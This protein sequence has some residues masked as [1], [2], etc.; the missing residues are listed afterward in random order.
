MLDFLVLTEENLFRISVYLVYVWFCYSIDA[1]P[2]SPYFG[3]LVNHS[4]VTPNCH[5]KVVEVKGQPHLVLLASRKIEI[6]EEL[7]YDYGDRSKEALAAHPW[8]AL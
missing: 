6:G 8:L 1:T 3:R 7:L 2:E 4:R 5:T